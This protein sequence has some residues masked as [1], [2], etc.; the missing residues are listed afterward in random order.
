MWGWQVVRHFP[1]AILVAW[2]LFAFWGFGMAAA[3]QEVEE[4]RQMTES[5]KKKEKERSW[6]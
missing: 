5:K 3:A 6:R 1:G 2:S 4:R